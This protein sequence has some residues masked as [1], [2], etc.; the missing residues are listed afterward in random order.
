MDCDYHSQA[1][2]DRFVVFQF[3]SRKHGKPACQL[4]NTHPRRTRTH[5]DA[6]VLHVNFR[7]SENAAESPILAR[8]LSLSR[9]HYS[10]ARRLFTEWA[11]AGIETSG[12]MKS[13]C[14]GSKI[15]LKKKNPDGLN[16]ETLLQS[17]DTSESRCEG[18][19]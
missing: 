18:N 2:Y 8:S 17:R 12:F 15:S 4:K 3:C 7:T 1:G 19:R 16:F 14:F 9:L 5:R 13:K 11:G 6:H 10:N